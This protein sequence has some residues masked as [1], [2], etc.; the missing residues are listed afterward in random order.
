MAG[1]PTE[2]QVYD[3]VTGLQRFDPNNP[4]PP[5]WQ[6]NPRFSYLTISVESSD[7]SSAITDPKQDLKKLTAEREDQILE[8]LLPAVTKRLEELLQLP[9][10]ATTHQ[11]S[12]V[13]L[14]VDSLA[15]VDL[16]SWL[17]NNTGL[18]VAVFRILAASNIKTC[19]HCSESLFTR[20]TD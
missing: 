1:R 10:N 18:D 4:N 19:M 2:E 14:G 16:R 20:K 15:A 12:V 11:K 6:R 3:I 5:H 9:E 13:E 17:W 7:T 8:A